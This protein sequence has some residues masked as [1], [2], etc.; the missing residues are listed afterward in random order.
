MK[1]MKQFFLTMLCMLPTLFANAVIVKIGDGLVDNPNLQKKIEHNASVLLTE[2]NRAQKSRAADLDFQYLLKALPDDAKK[3]MGM[4]WAMSPFMCEVEEITETLNRTST[5]Y[6]IRNIPLKMTPINKNNF[7]ESIYQEAVIRFNTTGSIV[8][9]ETVVTQHQYK[10]ILSDISKERVNDFEQ[11]QQIID[12]V[13]QYRIAWM[14]KDINFI[15]QIFSDDALIITGTVITPTKDGIKLPSYLKYTTKRKEEY[16]KSLKR[17]F[18]DPNSVIRIIFDDIEVAGHPALQNY[19]GVT[20]KQTYSR[21]GERRYEDVGYVFLLWQF[22][23]AGKSGNPK[24]HVRTWQ[25]EEFEGKLLSDDEKIKLS[26]FE[27]LQ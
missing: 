17:T 12:F 21:N 23:E 2:I 22:P 9:F 26:D 3:S 18:S 13:E 6:E 19:Y 4:L 27:G 7:N 11:R 8:G 25:P 15:D 1:N 14:N 16:L 5:G 24:I 20:L 10:K